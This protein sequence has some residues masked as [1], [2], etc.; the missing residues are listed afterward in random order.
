MLYL[1]HG[2]TLLKN[3]A[4]VLCDSRMEGDVGVDMQV[5]AKSNYVVVNDSSMNGN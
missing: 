5:I 1:I 4:L 2:K 3:R